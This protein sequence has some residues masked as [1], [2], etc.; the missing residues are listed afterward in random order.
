MDYLV[1]KWR[2]RHSRRRVD[3]RVH[4]TDKVKYTVNYLFQNNS[5][6]KSESES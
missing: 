6:S 3:M 2:S 4:K 1:N 5:E